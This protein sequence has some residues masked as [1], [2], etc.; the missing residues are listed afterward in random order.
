MQIKETDKLEYPVVQNKKGQKKDFISKMQQVMTYQST[1]PNETQ[2]SAFYQQDA[3]GKK[4]H[5]L[6][7]INQ[8]FKSCKFYTTKIIASVFTDCTFIDCDFTA[9]EMFNV[10]FENCLFRGCNFTDVE[11]QDVNAENSKKVNCILNDIDLSKNV[12]GFTTDDTRIIQD[13][14][15]DNAS[16][17]ENKS[18][19]QAVKEALSGWEETEPQCFELTGQD[20]TNC[21]L[22]I[23]P[24][25]QKNTD[26]TE[27]IWEFVFFYGNESLLMNDFNLYGLSSED[28]QT[29]VEE[30]KNDVLI[31]QSEVIIKNLLTILQD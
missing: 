4:I 12:K 23:Y 22:A 29:Q 6:S 8:L 19:Y 13:S 3:S 28:I 31:N 20:D 17:S 10:K 2:K 14:V 26:E 24:N 27:D 9:S 7:L 5:E 25:S 16:E 1:N 15:E 30:W 11:M 18:V 21:G